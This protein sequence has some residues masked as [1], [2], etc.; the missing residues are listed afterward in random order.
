[1][2]VWVVGDAT[3]NGSETGT[4]FRQALFFKECGFNLHDTMIYQVPGVGAKGSNYSYWQV[5]EY[6][7]VFSKG[8]PKTIK[9]I[10]DK[11]NKKAGTISTSNKQKR[12]GVKTRLHPAGGTVVGEYG[13]RDNVW[14]IPSGN[15]HSE[16]TGH[17]APFPEAL[18][19]DHIISWSNES[20]IVLDCFSGS[21]TTPK[22]A[23]LL[24]RHYIGIDTS[25]EYVELSRK[26]LGA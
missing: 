5:F 18:A 20:D 3:V 16:Y 24:N 11:K 15:G 4:S 12:D 13:I 25:I 9:R 21:G 1:M 23:K 6:M 19:R 14:V 8:K 7:F 22:M 17:P 10:K 2:V 26:R